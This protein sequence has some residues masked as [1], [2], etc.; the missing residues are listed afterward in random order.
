MSIRRLVVPGLFPPP[1]YAHAVT[2]PT[3]Q[4]LVFTAGGVPLDADG[5][6]VG[7]DDRRAQTEKVIENLDAALRAA[8]SSLAQVIYTDVYVVGETSEELD[9]AWQVVCDS[10]LADGPHASTLLGVRALG[11]PGQLVEI[12]AIAAAE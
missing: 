11:Y 8:G 3:G 1:H 12:T 7:K 2:V 10:E 5:N 4:P 6:L 9:E